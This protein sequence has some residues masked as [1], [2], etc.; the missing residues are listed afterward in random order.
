MR[1][2]IE[3]LSYRY[4]LW[5]SERYGD[6]L[7]AGTQP[8]PPS[9]KTETASAMIFRF[10]WLIAGGVLLLAGLRSCRFGKVSNRPRTYFSR[11]DFLGP[12]LERSWILH[13][14]GGMA[15]KAE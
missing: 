7:G 5:I 4:R 15:H 1:E 2:L 3:R 9:P 6:G 13:D 8:L 14:G 12:R 10:L 11:G